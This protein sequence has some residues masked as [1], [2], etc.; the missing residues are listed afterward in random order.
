M[1]SAIQAAKAK[2]SN[3]IRIIFGVSVAVP[4]ANRPELPI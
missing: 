2:Y 3:V 4:V 1:F